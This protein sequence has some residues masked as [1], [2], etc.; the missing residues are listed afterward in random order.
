[1]DELNKSQRKDLTKRAQKKVFGKV[2]ELSDRANR[3]FRKNGKTPDDMMQFFWIEFKNN[4]W[5]GLMSKTSKIAPRHTRLT[6]MYF[7]IAV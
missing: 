1:V 7:G 6:V 5:F 2:G 3:I 4:Y